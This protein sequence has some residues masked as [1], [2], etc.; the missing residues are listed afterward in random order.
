MSK[1]KKLTV[2]SFREGLKALY[3]TEPKGLIFYQGCRTQGAVMRSPSNLNICTDPECLSCSQ[4]DNAMKEEGK[5][6]VQVYGD[7]AEVTEFSKH[8][9]HL[10]VR[11]V[12][13]II[14]A[15]LVSEEEVLKEYGEE[16]KHTYINGKKH[17]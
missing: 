6:I 17:R 16:V 7:K 10:N 4:L 3:P 1:Y 14:G 9:H 12:M 13:N 5:R 8:L 11:P 15:K 2:E